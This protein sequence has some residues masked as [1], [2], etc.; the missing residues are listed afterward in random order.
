MRRATLTS[1]LN[2]KSVEVHATTEHSASSYGMPVW[3]DDE[4]KAY[5]QVGFEAPFYEL[6]E[7]EDNETIADKLKGA[8][9]KK[10]MTLRELSELTG[11]N[12]SNISRI[13]RGEVSPYLDTLQTLC[14]AL[15]LKLTIS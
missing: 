5:C 4:G 13:E 6:A 10:G 9:E 14:K 8:R 1:T 15:G 3:V 12:T 2:G 11:I 7:A